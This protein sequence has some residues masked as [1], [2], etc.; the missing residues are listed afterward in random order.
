MTKNPFQY[1]DDIRELA[2]RDAELSIGRV[3][4]VQA[5]KHKAKVQTAA[6]E[7]T[8]CD[9]SIGAMGDFLLPSVGTIVILD[10]KKDEQST[11]V[12][13][14]YTDIDEVPNV[15]VGERVIGHEGSSS[16]IHFANDGTIEIKHD[17]SDTTITINEDG[18]HLGADGNPIA[19]KGDAVE[20]DGTT[21]T[22]T[23]GS[24]D[25]T[26]S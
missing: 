24:A 20:V 12:G 23:E 2:V 15:E 22:I 8:L 3:D 14:V 6:N 19:R 18:V 9:V 4:G 26:A 10:E 1:A 11:I 5:D 16:R 25:H 17:A 13:V 7:Y 21:G